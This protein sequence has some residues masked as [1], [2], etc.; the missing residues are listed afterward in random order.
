MSKG[1]K[2]AV[3]VTGSAGYLGSSICEMLYQCGYNVIGVDKQEFKRPKEW[4]SLKHKHDNVWDN[5]IIDLTHRDEVC[6][7]LSRIK[8][9]RITISF[10]INLAGLTQ[11]GESILDPVTTVGTNLLITYNLLLMTSKLNPQRV[12]N[13]NSCTYRCEGQ[14]W[15]PYSWSKLASRKII[16]S[17]SLFADTVFIDMIITNPIGSLP[18]YHNCRGLQNNIKLSLSTGCP[19][20]ITTAETGKRDT[21][22]QRNFISIY[23]LLGAFM[24]AMTYNIVDDTKVFCGVIS[25]NKFKQYPVSEFCEYCCMN[26][27]IEIRYESAKDTGFTAI[28][29]I[30]SPLIPEKDI[31]NYY[32]D[33]IPSEVF[34]FKD[35]IKGLARIESLLKDRERITD[36]D[37]RYELLYNAIAVNL[38]DEDTV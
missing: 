9:Q 14:D 27:D 17:S 2:N 7:L 3:L 18:Y 12:I 19:M 31:M 24:Y 1:Y 5:Y 25:Q 8:Q 16:Q 26:T 34:V 20:R 4:G 10:I 38:R 35:K 37:V 28:Q 6:Y 36:N 11:I 33:N 32:I 13:A 30:D 23:E 29:E 21:V 22:Y 15:N